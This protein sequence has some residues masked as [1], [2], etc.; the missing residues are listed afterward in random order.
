MYD[1]VRYV[2]V[3]E[4]GLLYEILFRAPPPRLPRVMIWPKNEPIKC[5]SDRRRGSLTHVAARPEL[6]VARDL[7]K[8]LLTIDPSA[9]TPTSF[10][11]GA[12]NQR[13]GDGMVR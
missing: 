9:R 8:K 5:T 13:G 1:Y 11:S 6:P 12:S 7:C 4:K 2:R 10:Q 3:C